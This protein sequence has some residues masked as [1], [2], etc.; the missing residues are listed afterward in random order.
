MKTVEALARCSTIP[1]YEEVTKQACWCHAASTDDIGGA[2]IREVP[3]A[4][5]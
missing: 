3:P 5:D 2:T 4:R 1:Y